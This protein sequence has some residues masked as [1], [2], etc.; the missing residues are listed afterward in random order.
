MSTDKIV[1]LDDIQEALGEEPIVFDDTDLIQVQ[2]RIDWRAT[3]EEIDKVQALPFGIH[4][5]T[6]QDL[7]TL[8]GDPVIV[9]AP[10]MDIDKRILVCLGAPT[11][12]NGQAYIVLNGEIYAIQ[13]FRTG[14]IKL[15]SI[16]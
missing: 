11:D 5:L 6:E 10:G 8:H 15:Y 3:K 16:V 7:A 1:R 13:L 12:V 2:E 4:R 9:S 14:A